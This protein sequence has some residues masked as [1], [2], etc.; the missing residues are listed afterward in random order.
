[1]RDRYDVAIV[2]SLCAGAALAGYLGGAGIRVADFDRDLMRSDCV[3]S[4]HAIHPRMDVLDELGVGAR[5]LE[6]TPA[7]AVTRGE[8]DGAYLDSVFADGRAEDC[9]RRIL[10]DGWLQDAAT[11]AGAELFDRTT[12][13]AVERRN[14]RVVGLRV[15]HQGEEREIACDLLVGADGRRSTVAGL[16]LAHGV[17]AGRFNLLSEFLAQGRRTATLKKELGEYQKLLAE[18]KALRANP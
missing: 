15:R 12:A 6:T 10:L 9:P 5:V 14:G 17:A 3:L 13:T 18:T 16:A 2:G 8:N 1:M 4:T 7:G 11:T